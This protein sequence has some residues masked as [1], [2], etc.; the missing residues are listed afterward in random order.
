MCYTLTTKIKTYIYKMPHFSN[1][2]CNVQHLIYHFGGVDKH[3][4]YPGHLEISM[5]WWASEF[6]WGLSHTTLA[7]TFATKAF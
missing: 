3:S 4:P 5:S 7:F 6:S 1:R 2:R